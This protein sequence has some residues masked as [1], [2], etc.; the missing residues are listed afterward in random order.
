MQPSYMR[1]LGL[2]GGMSWH[3]SI[4]YYRIIN[5][6][7]AAEKGGHA[8]APLLLSSVNFQEIRDMQVDERWGDADTALAAEAK[9]LEAAGADAVMICTN[10]M[11]K[12]APAV[13]S[14]VDIP[15]LHIGDA[16]AYR[17]HKE[18]IGAVGILGTKWVMGQQFYRE[19]LEANGLSV[20]VPDAKEHEEVDRV[21]FDELTKGIVTKESQ[22]YYVRLIKE[23]AEQGAGA[24]VLGC[25][26][27]EHL[28]PA[29]VSPLPT[30]DSMRSHA[31]AGARFI[32]EQD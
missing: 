23:L 14:A 28:I 22:T 12:C 2:I 11:H 26:E 17:A 7:V 6:M 21:I 10:L 3:S 5:T 8:S 24:V 27:I 31:E 32:L 25:T 13:Q 18:G 19:R 20:V 4:E 29:E 30:I 9:K 16:I 15:L 1:T